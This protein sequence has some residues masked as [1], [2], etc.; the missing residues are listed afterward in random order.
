MAFTDYPI[1]EVVLLTPAM[2]GW[3]LGM[4]CKRVR[5]DEALVYLTYA[6]KV[7]SRQRRTPVEDLDKLAEQWKDTIL[8]LLLSHNRE[9]ADMADYKM[10][11]LFSALCGMP[12]SQVREFYE[13]FYQKMKTDD[14][15]PYFLWKMVEK[16]K[17]E[18]VKV[19]KE[20]EGKIIQAEMAQE[21]AK[22]LEPKL[23]PQLEEALKNS[24]KWRSEETLTKIKDFVE[25]GKT[26]KLA[27]KESCLFI[28]LDK[29]Q[30]ML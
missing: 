10:D 15:A 26:P 20:I 24:L 27:G 29:E 6:T 1:K 28:E 5:V 17:D 13:L 8:K 4:E 22:I 30:I 25:S 18:A 9:T 12:I 11:E 19:G 3:T 14:R 21:L 16:W 23:S 2:L 7:W